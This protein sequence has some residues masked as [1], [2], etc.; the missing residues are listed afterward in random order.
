MRPLEGVRILD[1]SHVLA[2]PYCTMILGD[3]GADIIKVEKSEGEDSRRF[4]PYKNGES[5]YYMSINRNKKSIVIN[6]KDDKGKEIL[7]DLIK[8]SDVLTE[9]FRPGTMEKLGFSYE[10]VKKI[11]PKIIYATISQFGNDSIY[12]GRPGY[13][14]IA[15][16]Y[17]GLM[18][19]TGY[20]ESPPTLS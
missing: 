8:I 14:I 3:L 6:L 18:S 11:N 17:A 9:N 20:P 2:M 16:A 10:E 1:L 12:P 15:Q 19:I 7:K 13:D 5:A 4:G